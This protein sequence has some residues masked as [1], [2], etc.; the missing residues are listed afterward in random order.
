[1]RGW[2]QCKNKTLHELRSKQR[3]DEAI[4]AEKIASRISDIDFELFAAVQEQTLKGI[5]ENVFANR[6]HS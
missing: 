5:K 1:L 4:I 2:Q 6:R 3:S